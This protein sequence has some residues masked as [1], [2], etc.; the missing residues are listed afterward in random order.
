[1]HSNTITENKDVI[2]LSIYKLSEYILLLSFFYKILHQSNPIFKKDN[3]ITLEQFAWT[4]SGYAWLFEIDW[5]KLFKQ[6]A[7]TIS[8]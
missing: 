6:Y 2:F 7:W 4:I 1:M 5:L 3:Y 8:V